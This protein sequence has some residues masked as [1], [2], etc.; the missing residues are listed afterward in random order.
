M[1]L[2]S[3]VHHSYGPA[4]CVLHPDD[5]RLGAKVGEL[6]ASATAEGSTSKVWRYRS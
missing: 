4:V 5:A 1:S 2:H 3:R 6:S